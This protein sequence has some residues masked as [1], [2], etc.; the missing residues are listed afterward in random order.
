MT[1]D[2]PSIV[3]EPD[4]ETRLRDQAALVAFHGPWNGIGKFRGPVAAASGAYDYA[5]AFMAERKKR[6]AEN[7][8]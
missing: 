7:G 3:T 6:M 1:T 2:T 8:K 4:Y 5:D